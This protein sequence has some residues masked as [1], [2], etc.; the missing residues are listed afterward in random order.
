MSF[1]LKT[2]LGIAAIEVFLLAILVFSSLRY[3]NSSTEEQLLDRASATARLFASMTSDA[4]VSMDLATLDDMVAETLKTPGVVYARVRQDVGIVLSEAGDPE[5]LAAPFARDQSVESARS[6]ARLDADHPI[7]VAGRIFGHVEIGIGT[8]ALNATIADATRRMLAVAGSEIALVAVFG[9]LLGGILTRQLKSIQLGAR[10]VAAGEFGHTIDVRG[11]DELADT[12]KSFNRMSESL[13]AFADELLDARERAEQGR[14]R[15]ET[16]LHDAV[17]SVPQGILIVDEDERI[18]HWNSAYREIY[19]EDASALKD[20]STLQDVIGVTG[21]RIDANL[22]DVG[23]GPE[24]A[25]GEP[26]S[27]PRSW[28]IPAGLDA[29]KTVRLDDG[30]CLFQ[31]VRSMRNGGCVIVE[32]DVTPLYEA[33]ERTRKL[34]RDLLQTSKMESLGTLAGGIAHEINTPIQ[35][36]GDNLRFLN[37]SF[38]DLRRVIDAHER[39]LDGARRSDAS[40]DALQAVEAT[41]EDADLDF[42]FEEIPQ[43]TRQS[44]D[45]VGQ[46]AR[47][48]L[49]MKECSHPA[50]KERAR[51]DINAIIERATTVCRAEWKQVARLDLQLAA[52]LPPLLGFEGELNQVI[53]NMV[54]NAA[55][56]I[57][58]KDDGAG[59]ITIR[60]ASTPSGIELVVADTGT[61]IPEA[62][63]ERIF[64]PFFTTKDVGKGT[65]QGL[66]I[67]RDIVADK[68]GGT[69]AVET[70]PGE[71]TTFVIRFPGDGEP[72]RRTLE[73]AEAV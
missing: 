56:A 26:A 30:R 43:A 47:I 13:A 15:A 50:S 59:T 65:G 44:I 54:V 62:I 66:A 25:G 55:H 37:E 31:T 4:V 2:I 16:V 3:L 69:I 22:H 17:E 60:T 40:P 73:A 5:A 28:E 1:R 38:E 48:V 64:D 7:V 46:V 14:D 24:D 29:Q 20:A 71:G 45:G 33:Q 63:R 23:A 21:K 53:L 49:A 52:D 19:A 8:A 35:Y 36:I 12:A 72:E 61:G 58:E 11:S 6:D 68:H 39:F 42:L 57:A 32:T 27:D 18:L 34:E 67:C 9:F 41:R 51:V 70:S 10:K